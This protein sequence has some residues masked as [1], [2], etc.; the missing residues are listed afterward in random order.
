MPIPSQAEVH[1]AGS[2]RR[3]V[4]RFAVGLNLSE[5]GS[6]VRTGPTQFDPRG[7]WFY[8]G[9]VT[10]GPHV[11]IEESDRVRLSVGN[12]STDL[13]TGRA[14][15]QIAVGPHSSDPFEQVTQV[16]R[17]PLAAVKAVSVSRHEPRDRH[18]V[19]MSY[20]SPHTNERTPCRHCHHYGSLIYQGTAAWCRKPG[21]S[22]VRATPT[23]GCTSFTREPGADD[24]PD[25]TPA[26]TD[27]PWQVEK[28]SQLL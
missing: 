11:A 20:F 21:A 24:E 4:T 10:P 17:G 15:Q 28:T 27:A 18:D 5:G 25:K 9:A 3:Q 19:G 23:S 7:V 8:T 26:S 16:H 12:F 13:P 1:T 6:G 14:V 2:E 22:T